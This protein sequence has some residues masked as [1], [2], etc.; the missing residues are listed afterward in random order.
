MWR[1]RAWPQ[2]RTGVPES[3]CE[4]CG[5]ISRSARCHCAKS[6]YSTRQALHHPDEYSSPHVACSC[7]A[8]REPSLQADM[9]SYLMRR[10]HLSLKWHPG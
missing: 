9:L 8:V 4:P 3:G 1:M 10:P 2:T 5:L 7:H 6:E